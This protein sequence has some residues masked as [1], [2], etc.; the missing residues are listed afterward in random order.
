MALF[1]LD[2]L[3]EARKQFELA[4]RDKRSE[5]MARDWINY[6][7]NEQARRRSLADDLS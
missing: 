6:L 4:A 5:K 2:R 1:N 3:D 7:D